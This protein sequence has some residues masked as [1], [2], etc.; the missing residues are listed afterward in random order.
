[1]TNEQ[2]LEVLKPM[3]SKLVDDIRSEWRPYSFVPDVRALMLLRMLHH[4]ESYLDPNQRFDYACEL[5][6]LFSQIAM[7]IA[8][9]EGGII[10]YPSTLLN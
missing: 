5:D 4:Y 7:Y 6:L 3:I 1:M 10:E 9:W 2:K 8:G